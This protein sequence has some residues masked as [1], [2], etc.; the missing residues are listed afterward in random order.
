MKDASTKTQAVT[1]N[2][3]L[4]PDLKD[5]DITPGGMLDL[6][7]DGRRD[8]KEMDLYQLGLLQHGDINSRRQSVGANINIL[9]LPEQLPSNKIPAFPPAKY[10]PGNEAC[11]PPQFENDQ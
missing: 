8:T 5:T 2:T 3:N 11:T 6:D 10:F 7:G 4:S 9:S 1:I